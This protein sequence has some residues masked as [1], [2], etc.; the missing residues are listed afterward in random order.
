MRRRAGATAGRPAARAWRAE[1]PWLRVA[2]GPPPPCG[3]TPLRAATTG[4]PCPKVARLVLNSTRR[5]T[6]KQNVLQRGVQRP[7]TF[8]KTTNLATR[9]RGLD[10]TS[11][12]GRQTR[13]AVARA[14]SDVL[15]ARV[16]GLRRN[17]RL[18]AAWRLAPARLQGRRACGGAPV[19]CAA[20]PR[21]GWRALGLHVQEGPALQAG[22]A[23]HE[24]R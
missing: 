11:H 20:T 22:Q 10:P 23:R 24:R 15:R 16:V 14:C 13:A 7:R 8:C 6:T 12:N 19:R 1:G 9:D 3:R 2:R 18:R 21:Q 5:A 17:G 4:I